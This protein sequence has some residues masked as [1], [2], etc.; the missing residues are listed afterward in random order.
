MYWNSNLESPCLLKLNKTS[1]FFLAENW[2]LN[3]IPLADRTARRILE[4]AQSKNEISKE[5]NSAKKNEDVRELFAVAIF[6]RSGNVLH[7]FVSL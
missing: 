4:V 6:G 1:G 7:L 3:K 5:Q 2:N